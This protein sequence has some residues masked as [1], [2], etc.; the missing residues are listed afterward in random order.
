MYKA[1]VAPSQCPANCV[2]EKSDTLE[3]MTPEQV[4][5]E[6]DRLLKHLAKDLGVTLPNKVT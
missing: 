4:L 3:N 6:V 5:S 2:V 1:K